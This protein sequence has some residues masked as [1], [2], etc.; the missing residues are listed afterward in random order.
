LREPS[1]A[2]LILDLDDAFSC[3]CMLERG[4]PS[5]TAPSA[6]AAAPKLLA[7]PKTA[8]GLGTLLAIAGEPL[9][10]TGPLK[11]EADLD[12]RR[13]EA[14]EASRGAP[15]MPFAA[16]AMAALL[17]A[18][19]VDDML[20]LRVTRCG[21]IEPTERECECG[22]DLGSEPAMLDECRCWLVGRAGMD[23][24]FRWQWLA[25]CAEEHD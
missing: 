8:A 5:V 1:L 17:L 10:K 22:R 6:L 15:D 11:C 7:W 9:W 13:T 12:G 25:H 24:C 20:F 4:G 19:A 2:R 3:S 18:A 16:A 23:S 14:A 21:C